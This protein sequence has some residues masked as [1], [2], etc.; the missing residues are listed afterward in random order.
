MN[1]CIWKMCCDIQK[2]TPTK[3]SFIVD[4][5][6]I[7]F[8]NQQLSKEY[9]VPLGDVSSSTFLH[10]YYPSA[11]VT[12]LDQ[13]LKQIFVRNYN[14]RESPATINPLILNVIK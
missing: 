13:L 14:C 5:F 7:L 4:S 3:A 9:I 6:E 12:Y 8:H 1:L 10:L 11:D 2:D